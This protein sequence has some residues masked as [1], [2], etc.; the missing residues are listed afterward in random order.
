[1]D[2]GGRYGEVDVEEEG[3]VEEGGYGDT[4]TCYVSLCLLDRAGQDGWM[5][6]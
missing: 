6:R 5:D 1:M 4:G 2:V 3:V